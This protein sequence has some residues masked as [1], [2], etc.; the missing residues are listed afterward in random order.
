MK[1]HHVAASLAA[2]AALSACTS[3]MHHEP[4]PVDVTACNEHAFN[5]YFDDAQTDLTPEARDAIALQSRMMR[6]CQIQHVRIVGLADAPGDPNE[7][8]AISQQRAETV[9]R[10]LSHHTSWPQS[11][12]ELVARGDANATNDDGQARPMHRR[13]RVVVTA[14]PP[15]AH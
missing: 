2:A 1:I 10:F 4:A 14:A 11:S 12:F 13:A 6:G 9:A 15:A 8:L 3:M 7:N 5:V